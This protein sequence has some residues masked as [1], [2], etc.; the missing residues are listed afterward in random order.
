MLN[1]LAWDKK[2]NGKTCI[3]IYSKLLGEPAEALE[4][5]I[6]N[7]KMLFAET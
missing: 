7:R 3:A 5:A 1:S 4:Q 6:D 2:D